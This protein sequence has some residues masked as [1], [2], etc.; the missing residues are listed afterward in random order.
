MASKV[1]LG[2]LVMPN[3]IEAVLD[4]NGFL[5]LSINVAHALAVATLPTHHK[6]P[7]DRILVVQAIHERLTIMTR[8]SWVLTYPVATIQA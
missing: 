7:F 6:D 5:R 4:A 1:S 2:K 8:D 3:D